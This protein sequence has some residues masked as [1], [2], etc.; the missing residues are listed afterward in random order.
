MSVFQGHRVSR[1]M[2]GCMH[3]LG[4]GYG[5]VPAARAAESDGQTVAAFVLHER[6]DKEDQFQKLGAEF[7][8][9]GVAK[10]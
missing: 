8:G 10:T 3:G 6:E 9:L 7:P 4:H 5:S 2:Q 1:L